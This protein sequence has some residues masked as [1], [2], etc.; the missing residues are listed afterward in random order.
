VPLIGSKLDLSDLSV[1]YLQV[2]ASL[3]MVVGQDPEL[4]LIGEIVMRAL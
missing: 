4:S 2:P 1:I 3:R